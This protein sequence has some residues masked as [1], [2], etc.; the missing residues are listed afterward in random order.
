M[1]LLYLTSILIFSLISFKGSAQTIQVPNSTG[2]LPFWIWA[3]GTGTNTHLRLGTDFGHFG[4]ASLEIYQNYSGGTEQRPGK[5]VFNAEAQLSK[6]YVLDK[7]SVGTSAYQNTLTVG[8]NPNVFNGN[9]LV[10][11]SA[12]GSFAIN[13]LSDH[14]Y[15]YG[16]NRDIVFN[17]AYLSSILHMKAESGNIGIGTNEPGSAKLAVQGTI[18]STEVVVEVAPG[19]GPDYVFEENYELRSLQDT[20]QYILEN[21]HLPEIPSAKEMEETGIGLADMN[22]RLLRKIEEL[23][24]HQIELLEK[25]EELQNK[26]SLLESK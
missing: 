17:S 7:F 23:T 1:R 21:K 2:G 12:H 15:F 25:V 9:D 24:L 18:A 20:K 8:P 16:G 10:I 26:V 22:M 13:N 3:G 11:S 6:G 5:I 19:Q 14:T 4:D